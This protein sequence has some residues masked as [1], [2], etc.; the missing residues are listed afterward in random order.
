LATSILWDP[1]SRDSER[2][3]RL[4]CP[5]L[6][7]IRTMQYPVPRTWSTWQRHTTK[8][9]ISTLLAL[10]I[11]FHFSGR[12][13]S[14]ARIPAEKIRS[15]K[16]SRLSPA[17]LMSRPLIGTQS[18]IPK[19]F[20]QS[21]SSTKLP[22]KFKH[23]SET[24]MKEHSDWEYVLWTDDDNLELV[25]RFMPGF[26]PMYEKLEGPI[27]Q[28]DLI[29]NAYM[30]LFGGWVYMLRLQMLFLYLRYA[31]S[32]PTWT[33]SVCAHRANFSVTSTCQLYLETTRQLRSSRNPTRQR[34]VQT[35]N[36]RTKNV[37]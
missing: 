25:K 13:F 28:A 4:C 9:T 1:E 36:Q 6:S 11:V 29:R 10:L 34:S 32:T 17:D 18:K 26:L 35:R 33:W 12:T 27:F 7:L 5:K 14:T 8:L 24:C 2:H 3:C 30:Y 20:H 21:W 15:S 31:G 16:A 23:W 37:S 19:I 22:A